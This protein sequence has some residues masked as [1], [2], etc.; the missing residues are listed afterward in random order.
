MFLAEL[1]QNRIRNSMHRQKPLVVQTSSYTRVKLYSSTCHPV[2]ST[3]QTKEKIEPIDRNWD[4]AADSR[5]QTEPNILSA[6]RWERKKNAKTPYVAPGIRRTHINRWAHRKAC[7]KVVSFHYS[8]FFWRVQIISSTTQPYA[9]FS[10]ISLF[11]SSLKLFDSC[12]N[13]LW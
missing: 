8:H 6:H 3:R 5:H 13:E 4:N 11:L 10:C 1:E 2:T 9:V 12:I 7:H